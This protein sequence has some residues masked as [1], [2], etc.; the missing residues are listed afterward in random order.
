MVWAASRNQISGSWSI[1]GEV[2]SWVRIAKT[3]TLLG[4]YGKDNAVVFP[5]PKS[6]AVPLSKDFPAAHIVPGRLPDL[7]LH[8]NGTEGSDNSAI[9]SKYY[10]DHP[11]F[12]VL[13]EK[14]ADWRS[15]HPP[16]KKKEEEGE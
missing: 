3:L 8:P 14:E 16:R 13:V 10:A 4:T 5:F 11:P 15:V 2:F 6:L 1:E 7:V 9:V 12:S